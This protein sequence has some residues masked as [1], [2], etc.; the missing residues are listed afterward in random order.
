M[1]YADLADILE[2]MTDS[3]RTAT[4]QVRVGVMT[5]Y[6]EVKDIVSEKHS[7]RGNKPPVILI[8]I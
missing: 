1:T 5:D 8:E 6:S 3:E 2:S 7:L 4:V